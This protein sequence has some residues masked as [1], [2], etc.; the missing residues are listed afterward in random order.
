MIVVQIGIAGDRPCGWAYQARRD[1]KK[2]Q[3]VIRGSVQATPNQTILYVANR[4]L[5][6]LRA[7]KPASC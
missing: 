6:K 2:P 7:A 4:V 5:E 3:K 1:E